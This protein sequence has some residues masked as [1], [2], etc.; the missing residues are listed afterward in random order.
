MKMKSSEAEL[1]ISQCTCDEIYNFATGGIFVAIY[2]QELAF[3]QIPCRHY[4]SDRYR[5]YS[6]LKK[7]RILKIVDFRD[8][9]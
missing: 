8:Y 9:L 2:P 4:S 6:L 5:V 7:K 3:S 1:R